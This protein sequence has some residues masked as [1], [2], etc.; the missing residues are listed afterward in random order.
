MPC[1]AESV[2]MF[3]MFLVFFKQKKTPSN[4][5]NVI[6]LQQKL[7]L[8]KSPGFDTDFCFNKEYFMFRIQNSLLLKQL[9]TYFMLQGKLFQ[10]IPKLEGT[11]SKF[12]C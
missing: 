4:D 3:V 12:P 11:H 9:D 5:K 7:K 8:E 1:S 10:S 2:Q 6:E